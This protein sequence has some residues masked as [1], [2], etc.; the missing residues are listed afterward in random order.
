MNENN[1]LDDKLKTHQKQYLL[2]EE[3][4]CRVF[5]VLSCLISNPS[6][7][8]VFSTCGS[9]STMSGANIASVASFRLL[10]LLDR[11]LGSLDRMVF[12]LNLEINSQSVLSSF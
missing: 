2:F 1:N 6:R 11:S 10:V 3:V 7:Y 12:G 9:V 4:V 5:T 8:C